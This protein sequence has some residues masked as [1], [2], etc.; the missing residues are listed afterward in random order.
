MTAG[1]RRARLD[2]A[3]VTRALATTRS[4]ARGLI[5][6]GR[7]L[8]DGRVVD[9]AGATVSAQARVEVTPGPRFVSRAGE[10]LAHA[11][12][13]FGVPVAGRRALDVGASTGGFVD[14]LLQRGAAQVIALDVGK[15]QLDYRLRTDERVVV[16]E[17]T[18]ARHLTAAEL[19]FAA[20]VLTMDVSFISVAKV[21]PAVVACLA[22]VFEGVILVKPQFEAGPAK[23]GKGGI[24]RDPAVHRQVVASVAQAVIAEVG[25]RVWGVC[26]SGLPG[27]GGN[28]EFFLWAGRGGAKC[29]PP[30]TL[31]Q[32]IDEAVEERDGA[33]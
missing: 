11:L 23:V 28:R 29:L 14:C 6:A 16:R 18:N 19:P 17:G 20:D 32:A 7:V 2:E 12:D 1:V 22:D 25:L 15:G 26:H 8:V 3:V 10:K 30:A 27:V 13:V 33:G 9:K 5:M 31:A 21:L 4:E 24:V